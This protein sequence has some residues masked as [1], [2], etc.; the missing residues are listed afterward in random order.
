MKSHLSPHPHPPSSSGAHTPGHPTPA[1]STPRARCQ[2]S[3]IACMPERPQE[4]F[5]LAGPNLFAC[6]ARSFPQKPQLRAP[7][8]SSSPALCLVMDPGV[9]PEW[10]SVSCYVPP[11]EPL[12][13]ICRAHSGPSLNLRWP[14]PPRPYVMRSNSDTQCVIRMGFLLFLSSLPSNCFILYN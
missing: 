13:T 6:L 11:R 2:T 14:H 9:A 1:L 5:K 3:R 8:H 7:A 12:G 4:S 10:P